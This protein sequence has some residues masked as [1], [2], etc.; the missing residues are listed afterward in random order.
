MPIDDTDTTGPAIY[1][2]LVKRT[3]FTTG[4]IHTNYESDSDYFT[5][6]S[7]HRVWRFNRDMASAS[8]HCFYNY[9][10]NSSSANQHLQDI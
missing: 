5:L 6:F 8:V 4:I 10:H 3:T 1:T 9:N 7:V 2:G